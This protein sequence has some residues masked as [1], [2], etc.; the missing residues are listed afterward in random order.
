MIKIGDKVRF[1][2]SV[3]G[4]IVRRFN[5]KDLVMVED[6]DGFEIPTLIKQCVVVNDDDDA[7]ASGRMRPHEASVPEKPAVR[8]FD[9]LIKSTPDRPTASTSHGTTKWQDGKTH[10]DLDKPV[11]TPEIPEGNVLNL[12]LAFIPAND[13]HL[14]NTNFYCYIVN[15]SNFWIFFTLL[16]PKEE[17]KPEVECRY[18][19]LIEPNTKLQLFSIDRIK[20]EQLSQCTIQLLAFKRDKPFAPQSPMHVDIHLNP[21]RFFKLHSFVKNDFFDEE[22]LLQPVVRNGRPYLPMNLDEEAISRGIREKVK[23]VQAAKKPSAR[24]VVEKNG[25]IEVDLHI[26]QL[27]DTTAG[28]ERRDMLRYQL[29]T[30]R[31]TMETYRNCRGK[32]IIFIHGKGEGVLR[33]AILDELKA[34]YAQCLWQDASFQQYGFGATQVTIRK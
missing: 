32:K 29:D 30:F 25:I 13:R 9:E 34:H 5:G 8:S 16:S 12:Y 20:A 2:D 11:R 27:L 23:S 21:N 1:L 4:G 3:G 28:M 31:K 24:P 17:G 19:G 33:K 26:G 18:T 14:Q 6:E 15:D 10:I 22:A 7:R